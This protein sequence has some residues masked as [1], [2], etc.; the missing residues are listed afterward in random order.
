MYKAYQKKK[1]LS[2][3]YKTRHFDGKVVIDPETHKKRLVMTAPYWYAHEIG[4]FKEGER[5][6]IQITNKRPKRTEQQN[7]Y[8]WG[9]YYPLICSETGETNPEY[10]HELFKAKFLRIGTKTILGAEISVYGSTTN[11]SVSEFQKFI[12]DIEILTG[13]QAPPVSDS[14]LA[15]LK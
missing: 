14:D 6:T 11:L 10:L 5:V 15:P 3:T 2:Y 7:R 4:K 9:V 8:I 1:N 13:I 12:M